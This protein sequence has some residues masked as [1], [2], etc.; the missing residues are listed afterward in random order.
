MLFSDMS[1]R[2]VPEK[3]ARLERSFVQHLKA[4]NTRDFISFP[5]NTTF[6][7]KE[8]DESVVLVT[9][10]HW[11]AVLPQIMAGAGVILLSLFLLALFPSLFKNVFFVLALLT[12]S[13]LLSIS[14]ALYAYLRW[15]Y[16]VNIIT[17]Q[18]VIDID[19]TSLFSHSTTEARLDKIE[20]VTSKQIGILS[21]LI[22][23][24]T[25]YIQTA[26]AKSEIEF[27]NIPKPKEVQDILSDLLEAKHNK[28]I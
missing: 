19:F 28:E 8:E 16:N 17:D 11:T 26:G 3:F 15:Y 10:A 4:R 22:D 23:M 6:L 18:R 24:G 20:D 9:R 14:I 27:D 21:S 12:I 7:G 2:V 5:R 1:E 13:A 25:V